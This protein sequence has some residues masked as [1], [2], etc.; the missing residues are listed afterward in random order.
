MIP[1]KGTKCNDCGKKVIFFDAVCRNC[2]SIDLKPL[3]DSRWGIDSEAGVKYHSDLDNYIL[4]VLEPKYNLPNCRTFI[5]KYYVVNSNNKYFVDYI[6]NQYDNGKKKN[7][8]FVPYSFD[9]Y[10]SEP[11][12]LIEIE[13]T[14]TQKDNH[15]RTIFWNLENTTI[16]EMPVNV[17]RKPELCTILDNNNISYRKSDKL[18]T[19]TE[20]VSNNYR[21]DIRE[22]LSLRKKSLGKNRG[23][24]SRVL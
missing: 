22:L 11:I 9:F 10:M 3:N 14:V 8:N 5:Y 7:C 16:E 19:L 2:D 4:Q 17:L 21:G 12:K 15:Y 24:T 20:L 23:N 6:Q 18:N 1:Q 13:I